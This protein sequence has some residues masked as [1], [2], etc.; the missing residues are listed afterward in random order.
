MKI[1]QNIVAGDHYSDIIMS[2]VA[3]RITDI[4]IVYSTVY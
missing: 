3:S 2:A 1:M 4:S